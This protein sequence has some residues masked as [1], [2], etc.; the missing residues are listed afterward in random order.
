MNEFASE[1]YGPPAKDDQG[2]DYNKALEAHVENEKSQLQSSMYVASQRD[3]DRFGRANKIAQKYGVAPGFVAQ[4]TEDFER[5][6]KING[7]DYEGLIKANPKLTEFLK[8][9]DNA[10]LAQ[11]DIVTGKQIGRAHV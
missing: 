6:E 8:D 4:N 9:P 7:V 10:T 5:K 1:L 2:P 11:D 3:P